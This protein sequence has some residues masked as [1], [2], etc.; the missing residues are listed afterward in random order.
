MEGFFRDAKG[1][2]LEARA[3]AIVDLA[4]LQQLARP[5]RTWVTRAEWVRVCGRGER[6]GDCGG[7][8]RNSAAK[9]ALERLQDLVR[10]HGGCEL[11]I[12]RTE[13]DESRIHVDT[14]ELRA[15]VDVL[16]RRALEALGAVAS[17]P[18]VPPVLNLRSDYQDK[19]VRFSLLS[20]KYGMGRDRI[21]AI[22]DKQRVEI[23]EQRRMRITETRGP[24]V[25]RRALEAHDAGA[26]SRDVAAILG[27]TQTSALRFL[28]S[29][30]R[31]TR[32]A[33]ERGPPAL[34]PPVAVLVGDEALA[35]AAW[36][37]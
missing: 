7:D 36:A 12:E 6:A 13:D 9:K 2:I 10:E 21:R 17:E 8:W 32:P 33:E 20:I 19:K 29:H 4:E 18:P 11:V 1:R 37:T 35:C 27:V 24:E 28:R 34:D 5:A 15:L 14:P 23:R 26:S 16:E 22:L 25:I 3:R 31:D 30:G